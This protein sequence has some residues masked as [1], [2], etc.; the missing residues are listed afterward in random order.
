V[1]AAAT[2]GNYNYKW[3]S[4]TRLSTMK[5]MTTQGTIR[6]ACQLGRKRERETRSKVGARPRINCRKL[7][8]PRINRE[9]T[10][11]EILGT[12]DGQ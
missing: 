2:S 3:R 9:M 10:G 12:R 8:F 6:A 4:R 1:G 11:P 7:I 5:F